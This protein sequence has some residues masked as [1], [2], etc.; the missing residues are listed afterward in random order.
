MELNRPSFLSPAVSAGLLR[1]REGLMA[2]V[3]GVRREYT[4]RLSQR[5]LL[6]KYKA[7]E[8]AVVS[9]IIGTDITI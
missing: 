6:Y 3:G 2:V 4:A 7:L 8:R 1:A 5:P 9:Q